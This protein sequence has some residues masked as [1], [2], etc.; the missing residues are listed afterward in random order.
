M[1]HSLYEYFY[2]IQI[3]LEKINLHLI[4][5]NHYQLIKYFYI[6]FLRFYYLLDILVIICIVD[7][8]MNF[9]G[10]EVGNIYR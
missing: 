4:L 9:I 8:F 6:P 2:D 3:L 5:L 7:F 10:Y 1:N